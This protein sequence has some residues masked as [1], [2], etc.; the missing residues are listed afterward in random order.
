M[1]FF[2]IIVKFLKCTTDF[3]KLLCSIK[4]VFVSVYYNAI[5]IVKFYAL[6]FILFLTYIALVF[7]NSIKYLSN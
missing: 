7:E 2:K 1:R 3:N 6:L 5:F 4:A